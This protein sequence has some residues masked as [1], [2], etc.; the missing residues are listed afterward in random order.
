[1]TFY[2]I[3][4]GTA[5]SGYRLLR[6]YPKLIHV[7]GTFKYEKKKFIVQEQRIP[8]HMH[9]KAHSI[10]HKRKDTDDIKANSR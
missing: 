1:M 2:V 10:G 6:G 9:P 4:L 8:E 5:V 3:V 7:G